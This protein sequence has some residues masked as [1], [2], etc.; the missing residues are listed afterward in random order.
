MPEHRS[1]FFSI[2]TSKMCPRKKNIPGSDRPVHIRFSTPES[3]LACGH[4]SAPLR[5]DAR[6]WDW[7][8]LTPLPLLSPSPLPPQHHQQPSCPS[9]FSSSTGPSRLSASGRALRWLLPSSFALIVSTDPS[10]NCS[11]FLSLHLL[12]F[13]S[14]EHSDKKV[15]GIGGV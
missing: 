11:L 14:L 1:F 10:T 3:C 9:L 6:Q 15:I 5:A 2:W 12:S 4:P 8:L 7:K 13:Y